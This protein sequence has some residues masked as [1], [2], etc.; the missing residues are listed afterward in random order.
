LYKKRERIWDAL[1]LLAPT[2]R[3]GLAGEGC[4]ILMVLVEE[5]DDVRV[6]ILS[7]SSSLSSLSFSVDEEEEEEEE[8][9]LLLQ[10]RIGKLRTPPLADPELIM[11]RSVFAILLRIEDAS[12]AGGIDVPSPPPFAMPSSDCSVILYCLVSVM[13][14]WLLLVVWIDRK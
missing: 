14:V 3:G 1:V 6:L 2:T 8:E 10:T 12:E 13:V 4:N 9:Q 5:M 7:M 11:L